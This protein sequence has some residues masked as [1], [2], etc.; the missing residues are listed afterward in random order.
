MVVVSALAVGICFGQSLDSLE[1]SIRYENETHE[2]MLL[3]LE[4]T[5]SKLDEM[6]EDYKKAKEVLAKSEV[7]KVK[8]QEGQLSLFEMELELERKAKILQEYEMN[9]VPKTAL[10]I[11]QKFATFKTSDT[12]YTNVT[13]RELKRKVRI[14]H[15]KGETLVS[16]M[17][18]PVE[19]RNESITAPSTSVPFEYL[20][21]SILND[22]PIESLSDEHRN[23]IERLSR[24]RAVLEEELRKKQLAKERKDSIASKEARIAAASVHNKKVST[25]IRDLQRKIAL[26][27]TTI[28]GFTAERRSG[29][30]K[31]G[32]QRI[33][34]RGAHAA[35]LKEMDGKINAARIQINDLRKQIDQL[36]AS[37]KRVF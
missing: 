37:R 12:V 16:F 36:E 23:K 29:D 11:G 21:A 27:N 3:D 19:V 30:A 6:S 28:E 7:A 31:F 15:D 18:L 25:D 10:Q 14:S 4:S 32:S 1:R 35:F 13:I 2:R 34:N 8:L 26:L 22:R 5:Q 24:E 20:P 33:P 9:F 17:D